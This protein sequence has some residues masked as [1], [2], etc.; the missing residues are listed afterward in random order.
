MIPAKARTM[1][2]VCSMAVLDGMVVDAG[3]FLIFVI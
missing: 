2:R 3:V 1:S